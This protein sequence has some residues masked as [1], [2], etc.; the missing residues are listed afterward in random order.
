[1]ANAYVNNPATGEPLELHPL[2]DDSPIQEAQAIIEFEELQQSHLPR[3]MCALSGE[4]QHVSLFA[5]LQALA[6]PD[7]TGECVVRAQG[8]S[9]TLNFENGQLVQARLGQHSGL[10]ALYRLMALRE[11]SFE[12]FT[13]GRTPRERNLAGTLEAHLL[14][15]AQSL[16]EQERLREQVPD[17][18][19]FTFSSKKVAP[20]ARIP[21]PVLQVLAAIHQF[22]YLSAVLEGCPLPDLEIRRIVLKLL[23]WEVIFTGDAEMA[24]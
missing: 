16:D 22:E 19:R 13:P 17:D 4:L 8:R 6:A 12:Y 10:K 5:A 7:I 21:A 14:E 15:A 2:D 3:G 9:G 20:V 1:M 23:Q 11:G 24:S 18:S